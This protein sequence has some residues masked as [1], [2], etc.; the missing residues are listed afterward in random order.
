MGQADTIQQ[1]PEALS[2]VDRVIRL[3]GRSRYPT[4]EPDRH[5]NNIDWPDVD[6]DSDTK[7]PKRGSYK[8]PISGG[9]NEA[10]IVQHWSS[11][12]LR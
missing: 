4:P 7:Q 8:Q 12:H 5:L 1:A 2:L 11:Y 6:P 3:F 9:Y 10:F